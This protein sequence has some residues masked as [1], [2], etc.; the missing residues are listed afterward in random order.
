MLGALGARKGETMVFLRSS[1]RENKWALPFDWQ[2]QAPALSLCYFILNKSS[3]E[4][5]FLSL[6]RGTS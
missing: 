6:E 4:A 5:K 2:P 3:P 1:L